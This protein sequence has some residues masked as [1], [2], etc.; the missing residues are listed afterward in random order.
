MD[1]VY[2]KGFNQDLTCRKFQYEVG[3]TY[4]HEGKISLC[5]KG[6][7]YCHELSQCFRYYGNNGTNKYCIVKPKGEVLKASDKLVTSEIEIVRELTKEEV[8]NILN[9]EAKARREKELNLDVIR[10]LQE[11][12]NIFF[13]GSSALYLYG[14]DLKREAGDL[15]VIMPYY[16]KIKGGEGLIEDVEEFDAKSSGN[17][18]DKTFLLTTKDGRFLKID[19]RINPTQ[20]YSEVEFKGYTY[21]LSELK[22]IVEAKARY[23]KQGNEKH[24]ND[25]LRLFGIEKEDKK[26]ELRELPF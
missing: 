16:Q 13:A 7:H 4:K 24:G 14:L 23:W 15:D 20:S 6:F 3:K 5:Y 19:L 25:F 26:Q 18:F 22:D 12:Y 1:T 21:K 2:Y 11:N 17:D 10:E 9:E 8:E